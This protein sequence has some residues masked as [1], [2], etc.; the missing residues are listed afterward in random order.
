M[1]ET[2]QPVQQEAPRQRWRAL[3]WLLPLLA[4]V[5]A[6][7][8][9]WQLHLTR[10]DARQA[11]SLN[12]E[13]DDRIANLQDAL[14]SLQQERAGLSQRLDDTAAVNRSL[15]EELLELRERTR[16][17]EDALAAL[18]E[19]RSNGT[20][21]LRLD[22]TEFLL[23][24]AQERYSLFHDVHGALD[25]AQLANQA[26]AGVDAPAYAPLRSD[27]NAAI[28]VL[29]QMD[30]EARATQLATLTGLRAAVWQ[31]P[32]ASPLPQQPAHAGVLARIGHALAGLVR[33][34]RTHEAPLAGVGSELLHEMLAL[35]LAQAQAALLA[36]N[37]PGYQ[38]ALGNAQALLHARFDSEAENARKFRAELDTLKAVQTAPVPQL[39]AALDDLRRIRAVEALHHAAKTKPV[40]PEPHR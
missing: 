9:L 21:A 11:L 19:N 31:L 39:G 2:F 17:L 13:Q 6:G 18:S 4:A 37:E 16:T 25:A 23:R 22:E 12:Q 26:M 27:L 38:A 3:L 34:R 36:W 28:T 7:A 15:R 20:Q 40:Q 33:I 24:I 30:P 35:D 10:Q 14:D 8:V 1:D 29:T 5:L 32:L